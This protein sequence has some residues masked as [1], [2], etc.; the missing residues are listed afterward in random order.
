M[1][2]NNSLNNYNKHIKFYFNYFKYLTNFKQIFKNYCLIFVDINFYLD[3]SLNNEKK[4]Y[5]NLF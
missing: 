1:Y 2:L 3:Y 4:S 5:L